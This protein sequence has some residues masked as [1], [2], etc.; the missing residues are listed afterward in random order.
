MFYGYSDLTT[1]LNAIYTKQAKKQFFIKSATFFIDTVRCS[2]AILSTHCKRM[3][4]ISMI[5]IIISSRVL[6][7]KVL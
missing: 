2:A 4:M 3:V 6:L 1:I 5:W 7:W